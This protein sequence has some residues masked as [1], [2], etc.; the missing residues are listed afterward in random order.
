M[1]GYWYFRDNLFKDC[2]DNA[3]DG[4]LTE[5]YATLANGILSVDDADARLKAYIPT[6]A[7]HYNSGDLTVALWVKTSN[8]TPVDR[9]YLLCRYV[10]RFS[11][12]SSGHTSW[13]CGRMNDSTGP[14]YSV[15]KYGWRPTEWSRLVGQYHPDPVGGNGWI[16]F[17]VNGELVGQTDIGSDIMWTGYGDTSGV[18]FGTTNH[19]DFQPVAADYKELV[20]DGRIWT[21]KEIARDAKNHP[22]VTKEGCLEADNFNEVNFPAP[23]LWY[24]S[25][26][27]SAR[28]GG[29]NQAHA[30]AEN[31]VFNGEA[32]YFNGTDARII[33]I[34]RVGTFTSSTASTTFSLWVKPY[35]RLGRFAGR[36]YGSGE[37][38]R[39]GSFHGAAG[40]VNRFFYYIQQGSDGAGISAIDTDLYELNKWYHL[41]GVA[42]KENQTVSLYVNGVLKDSRPFDGSL[43][44]DTASACI[45]YS[46]DSG[47]Y[48]YEFE[49]R[50]VLLIEGGIN[51][52]QAMQIFKEQSITADRV[53]AGE[54]VEAES[55]GN[56]L[57]YKNITFDENISGW[58]LGQYPNASGE[59]YHA[60]DGIFWDA[61][62][63]QKNKGSL[64]I[65][66]R[67]GDNSQTYGNTAHQCVLGEQYVFTAWV[68][69]NST[70]AQ[71]DLNDGTQWLSSRHSGSGEWERLAVV[72]TCQ[73]SNPIG[74]RLAIYS[75]TNVTHD[76]WF[77]DVG[78]YHLPSTGQDILNDI[79]ANGKSMKISG[80]KKV[81]V[82]DELREI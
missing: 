27:N 66:K 18:R 10:W 29:E 44:W 31:V 2:S 15:T 53:S 37:A 30:L 57:A 73:T 3:N 59:L 72:F 5:P 11:M 25:L 19:W 42:D 20:I 26:Q 75:P 35:Q 63:G 43:T 47:N 68:K 58:N 67:P 77:D 12:N 32:A 8:D 50:D 17:Y 51:A 54:F 78:L 61:A 38:S 64:K 71:L 9:Q 79:L 48:Y 70:H 7:S 36:I 41:I 21:D 60:D 80:D 49:C 69:A 81:Y 1:L 52:T 23:P 14:A 46:M 74:F 22:F 76:A 82:L 45:G 40:G 34:P 39:S 4:V 65:Q 55:A 6:N 16:R 24:Y 62:E 13:T 33:D 28:D 56:L